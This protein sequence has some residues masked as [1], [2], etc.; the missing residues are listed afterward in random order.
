[1]VPRIRAIYAASARASA[2]LIPALRVSDFCI[3]Q[4]LSDAGRPLGRIEPAF[5]CIRYAFGMHSIVFNRAANSQFDCFKVG[6]DGA[7]L[8]LD[9]RIA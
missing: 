8:F 3:L 6:S 2:I 5:D 4:Q 7:V 1:M 9:L